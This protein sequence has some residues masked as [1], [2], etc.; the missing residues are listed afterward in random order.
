[1]SIQDAVARDLVPVLFVTFL[2]GGGTFWLIV[3]TVAEQWRKLKTG[4]R[5]AALKQ[6]MIEAGYRAEEI[7]R[8]LKAGQEEG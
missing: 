5:N 6:A 2:F 4:E 1:M 7:V 3:A 8:V